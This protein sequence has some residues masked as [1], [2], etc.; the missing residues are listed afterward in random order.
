MYKKREP[1]GNEF[2]VFD[3]EEQAYEE[4]L[5]RQEIRRMNNRSYQKKVKAS[6]KQQEK[7]MK[8]QQKAQMK[9][10][11]GKKKINWVR[12]L[13]NTVAILLIVASAGWIGARIYWNSIKDQKIVSEEPEAEDKDFEPIVRSESDDIKYILVCGLDKSENLTDV[14]MVVCWDTKKNTANILQI[15]RDTFTGYDIPSGKINAVYGF[16]RKGESKP[17]ALCRRLNSQ[18]GLPIDHYVMINI[19]S[20][21]KIVD[22]LGGIEVDVVQTMYYRGVY[23]YPGTQVLD[24]KHA[25]VFMRFRKGYAMGD[26]GRVAMQR[27]FYAGLGEK[28]KN[29]SIKQVIDVFNA[30][31]DDLVTDLTYGEAKNYISEGK[32]LKMKKV[33]IF[34]VPGQGYD[35]YST[36]RWNSLYT[37]HKNNLIE[38]LNKYMNPF[39]E[40]TFDEST[41]TIPELANNEKDIIEEGGSLNNFKE[42]TKGESDEEDEVEEST[43]AQ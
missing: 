17:L 16:A 18:F 3:E 4:A 10:T 27:K 38:K 6:H 36:G 35:D 34:A 11:G 37:V 22:A 1:E 33:N 21:K 30:V 25:E 32:Q 23:I 40:L 20:F 28:L 29:M 41:V 9:Q 15:P 24:G 14:I 13:V 39:G 42:S 31:K 43:S 8:K 5:R 12:I 26:M 19:S 7:A 2:D